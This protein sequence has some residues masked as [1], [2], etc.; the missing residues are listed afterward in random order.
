MDAGLLE[1]G[2][3]RLA[4][5]AGR[6][7]ER[8]SASAVRAAIGRR[9]QSW[10]RLAQRPRFRHVRRLWLV[11]ADVRRGTLLRWIAR[12]RVA[13]AAAVRPY[14]RTRGS[15]VPRTCSGVERPRNLGERSGLLTT[16]P[17]GHGSDPG[18]DAE[19]AGIIARFTEPVYST[20]HRR[21]SAR[22]RGADD[23]SVL[24]SAPGDGTPRPLELS[25]GL[26]R[27]SLRWRTELRQGTRMLRSRLRRTGWR[28]RTMKA[29]RDEG[30]KRRHPLLWCVYYAN[31]DDP[32]G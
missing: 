19:T 8:G 28:P 16:G 30:R 25:W 18:F 24:E 23:F 21:F 31:T 29:A 15:L 2:R 9:L 27:A 5:G 13:A 10:C 26:L 4:L 14:R 3:G 32:S 17:S 6:V 1:C 11:V 20:R 12:M 7:D 22:W